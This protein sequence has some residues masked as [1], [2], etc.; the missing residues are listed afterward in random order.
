VAIPS[1]KAT[2]RILK[3]VRPLLVIFA[4]GSGYREKFNTFHIPAVPIAKIRLHLAK[5]CM[6]VQITLEDCS[7]IGGQILINLGFFGPG[8][9][10]FD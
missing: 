8:P 1:G 7:T 2:I 4:A 5:G 10:C 9:F 3:K 6:Q